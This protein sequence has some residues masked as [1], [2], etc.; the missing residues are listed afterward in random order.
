VTGGLVFEL[1]QLDGKAFEPV[2][3]ARAGRR[4]PPPRRG[5]RRK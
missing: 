3:G 2:E 1:I 4:G 5:R